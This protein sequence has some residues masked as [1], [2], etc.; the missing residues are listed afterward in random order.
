MKELEKQNIEVKCIIET[1]PLDKAFEGIPIVAIDN[2]YPDIDTI[3][4]VP[5]YDIENIKDRVCRYRGDI[6]VVG[7][8][9][10]IKCVQ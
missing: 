5:Y 1:Q 3:I 9:E 7:I 8:D 10:Y 4:V 6:K 2:L